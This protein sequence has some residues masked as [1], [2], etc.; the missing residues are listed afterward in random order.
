LRF[1]PTVLPAVAG[2]AM[3]NGR[4][5]RSAD[6]IL[7]LSDGLMPIAIIS[8]QD[9]TERLSKGGATGFACSEELLP[10]QEENMNNAT[11]PT[12]YVFCLDSMTRNADTWNH[13]VRA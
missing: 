10:G 4:T 9:C 7:T 2:L 13:E 12:A 3:W 5:S 6:I 11:K 8:P 1:E